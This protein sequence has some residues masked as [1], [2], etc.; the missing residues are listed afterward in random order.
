VGET[1]V[2]AVTTA[3]LRGVAGGK[4]RRR[5]GS[6]VSEPKKNRLYSMASLVQDVRDAAYRDGKAG[7]V[8]YSA[9]TCALVRILEA[10]VE[11]YCAAANEAE[12]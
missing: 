5:G 7:R 9:Q 6:G 8:G 10:V 3:G 2:S 12:T 1:G 4:E 11:A